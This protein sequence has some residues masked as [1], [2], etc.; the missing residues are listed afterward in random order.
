MSKLKFYFHPEALTDIEDAIKYYQGIS[1]D[2]P[3]KFLVELQQYIDAICLH[4][5]IF[6][7]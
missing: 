6:K 1:V 5:K 2:L 7:K 4:R 3:I